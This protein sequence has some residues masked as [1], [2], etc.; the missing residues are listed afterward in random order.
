MQ[1]H[2]QNAYTAWNFQ[3]IWL[4]NFIQIEKTM[5]IVPVIQILKHTVWTAFRKQFSLRRISE[6]CWN[7][8]AR[9]EFKW[10]RFTDKEENGRL[11]VNKPF[12]SIASNFFHSLHSL[13]Y[14]EWYQA[15]IFEFLALCFVY[16]YFIAP[17][18]ILITIISY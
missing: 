14:D 17:C 1:L 12:N 11:F 9:R 10:R 5:L 2:T 15:L 6:I 7:I 4:H 13:L 16:L 18:F 3:R 8:W